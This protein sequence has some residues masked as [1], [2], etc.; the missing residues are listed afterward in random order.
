[1]TEGDTLAQ[2][3]LLPSVGTS[4]CWSLVPRLS[5]HLQLGG[6]C[7][8][9][10]AAQRCTLQVA[11]R[12]HLPCL[13]SLALFL[14]CLVTQAPSFLAP[15]LMGPLYL[16]FGLCRD[17]QHCSGG[18]RRLHGCQSRLLSPISLPPFAIT[19]PLETT[20]DGERGGG[21]WGEAL[22][23]VHRPC[24]GSAGRN[25][26]QATPR[27]LPQLICVEC[28]VVG[29]CWALWQDRAEP[30]VWGIKSH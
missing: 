19:V 4:P 28:W 17:P 27:D 22:N 11:V 25:R 20:A 5:P 26:D 30:Q 8:A 10:R 2:P 3:G 29:L 9:G 13:H 6:G 15:V 16:R 21:R 23:S 7:R 1:M 14:P 12:S 24:S 18:K